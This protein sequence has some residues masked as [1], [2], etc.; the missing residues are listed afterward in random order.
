[1]KFHP[2][3]DECLHFILSLDNQ[4]VIIITYNTNQVTYKEVLQNRLC[5][6]S[7]TSGGGLCRVLFKA[8]L[9]HDAY[10]ALLESA[11][12]MLDPFPFGGGVTTLEALAMGTPVVTLPVI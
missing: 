11:S 9:E 3:F 4:A 12:V 2:K 8:A 5:N 6:H 1:M 7:S 10:L